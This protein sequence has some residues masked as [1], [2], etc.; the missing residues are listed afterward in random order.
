MKDCTQVPIA[1]PRL[2]NSGF[3][4]VELLTVISIIAILMALLLPALGRARHLANRV[5]CA[6]NLRNIG[7]AN[8]LYSIQYKGSYPPIDLGVWPFNAGWN[9]NRDNSLIGNPWG[10]S[11]LYNTGLL[12]NP[13]VYYCPESGLFGPPSAVSTLYK[14][15]I[16]PG[17]ISYQ[18]VTISYC[19]YVGRGEGAFDF[20][21]KGWVKLVRTTGYVTN[22]TTQV[23][24]DN[25]YLEPQHPFAQSP[26]SDP[27]TIVAADVMVSQGN[28]WFF[29]ADTTTGGTPVAGGVVTPWSNHVTS[30]I[31]APDGGNDLYNDGSVS[32]IG[33][34]YLQCRY[35]Y[36]AANG[37][38]FWQ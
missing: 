24:Y 29:N 19:Y 4:L 11:I 7:Q 28:S 27:G 10:A 22:P 25:N 8:R 17:S 20:D 9:I 33:F 2:H 12:P 13:A 38:N 31:G 1:K 30:P 35:T 34:P 14:T 15:P 18:P 6:S 3:S 36:P 16:A 23:V 5:V 21:T 32:W 37:L 26:I